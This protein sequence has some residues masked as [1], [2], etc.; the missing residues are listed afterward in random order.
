MDTTN[1]KKQLKSWIDG[2]DD[3]ALLSGLL[4]IKNDSHA[5]VQWEE[6][7][8]QARE[9][10]LRGLQDLQAGRSYSSDQMWTELSRRRKQR[11]DGAV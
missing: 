3:K 5:Y 7:P 10:A 11:E 8:E 4:A 9:S 2:L 1:A 6:L